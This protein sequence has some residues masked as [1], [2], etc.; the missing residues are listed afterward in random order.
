MLWRCL[1]KENTSKTKWWLYV[2]FSFQREA[3]PTLPD[4]SQPFRGWCQKVAGCCC[5]STCIAGTI[6][7][8][9]NPQRTLIYMNLFFGNNPEGMSD[10]GGHCIIIS[11]VNYHWTEPCLQKP[12]KERQNPNTR[13]HIFH[14]SLSHGLRVHEHV[15]V[16][17][18]TIWVSDKEFMTLKF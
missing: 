7:P 6:T 13:P 15:C 10:L 2:D 18:H 16:C 17:T 1:V 11:H 8:T 5:L 14:L 4:I 12:Y 9:S 3:R